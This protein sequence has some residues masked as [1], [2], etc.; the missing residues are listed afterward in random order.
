MSLLNGAPVWQAL[1]FSAVAYLVPLT[2][3]W[4]L[5]FT[6]TAAPAGQAAPLQPARMAPRRATL[7]AILLG[8]AGLSGLIGGLWDASK[9][10]QTGIIPAGADFLWAPHI[11]I[12]GTF[13]IEFLIGVATLGG[14]AR[15]GLRAGLRDPRLWVRQNPYL[16]AVGLA[17][18]YALL[19]VP[20][21]AIW[22]EIF[23]IDLTAWSPPHVMLCLTSNAVTLAALGLLLQFRTGARRPRWLNAAAAAFLALTLNSL[24]LVGV[25][26]WELPGGLGLEFIRRPVWLYPVVFG[27]LAFFVLGVAR[28][29]IGRGGATT[30]ALLTYG[31]RW[32][33]TVGLGLTGNV[34]PAML[35]VMLLGAAL[36]DLVP[37]ERIQRMPLRAAGMTA[38]FTAGYLGLALP[39]LM[40]RTGLGPFTGAG[41]ALAM[42]V[43]PVTCAA[44][45]PL[46]R[47]VGNAL[48]PR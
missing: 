7:V 31:L 21:D 2:L 12:Y 13:L 32:A 41:L 43:V 6:R 18:L 30:V 16:G 33:V 29:V 38:A 45:L 35:P 37:W 22:H 39:M 8:A 14:L 26:E 28:Q 34:V 24:A 23:G 44:L 20:G 48:L 46:V 19:S 9:H 25:L 27:C 36:L 5:F 10:V 40:Q 17:A 1:L 11:M 42:L 3:G 15:A 47:L 4:W